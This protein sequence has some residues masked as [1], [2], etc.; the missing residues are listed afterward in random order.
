MATIGSAE[1]PGLAKMDAKM[2]NIGGVRYWKD[3][4]SIASTA[5]QP[6]TRALAIRALG[7]VRE[8]ALRGA[9]DRWLADPVP[10]V[11]AAATVLL[12]DFSG[13]TANQHLTALADDPE[14]KVRE[15]A[16]R[17]IGYA[18]C[19]TSTPFQ[20]TVVHMLRRGKLLQ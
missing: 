14:P 2:N 9:V 17:A 11:R 4:E 8:P 12:A 15:C 6:A 19:V 16:A 10:V 3:L 13:P 1:V 20:D 18:R 5:K 7:L